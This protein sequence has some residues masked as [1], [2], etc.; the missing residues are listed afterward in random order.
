MLVALQYLFWRRLW[1]SYRSALDVVR[2]PPPPPPPHSCLIQYKNLFTLLAGRL[3]N[4][5]I[6]IQ[7]RDQLN[8]RRNF[9]VIQFIFCFQ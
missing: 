3:H 6:T 5:A 9:F 8:F 7:L 2:Q 4:L 1:S